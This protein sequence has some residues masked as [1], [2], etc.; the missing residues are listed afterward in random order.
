M[1]FP[2]VGREAWGV[3]TFQLGRLSV[4]DDEVCVQ[5]GGRASNRGVARQ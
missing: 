1:S 5:E 3:S 2:G 4:G